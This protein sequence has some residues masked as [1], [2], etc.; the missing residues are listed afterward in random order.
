MWGGATEAASRANSPRPSLRL[1][2]KPTLRGWSPYADF[3]IIRL[4][5]TMYLLDKYLIGVIPFNSHSNPVIWE[6]CLLL[7]L[8]GFTETQ[9]LPLLT[10]L[11]LSGFIV[12][13]G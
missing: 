4:I 8:T 9:S 5:T 10:C 11:A 3:L 13:W 2:I 7:N 6:K 1:C 12:V